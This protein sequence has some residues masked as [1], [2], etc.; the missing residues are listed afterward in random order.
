MG[1]VVFGVLQIISSYSLLQS[2][3]KI[4]QL[5]REAKKK[6]Y[7][8][9]ALT[10]VN[11]MYGVIEFYHECLAAGI[12]PILG[13][14]LDLG[15]K[16]QLL[17]LAQNERGYQNLMHISTRKMRSLAEG[18]EFF[19][20]DKED[21]LQELSIITPPQNSY[22]E[23]SVSHGKLTNAKNYLEKL[24]ALVGTSKNIYIGI[25][26]AMETALQTTL[27]QLAEQ[28]KIATVAVEPVNYLEQSD[29]FELQVLEALKDGKQLSAEQ[30]SVA[31]KAKGNAWLRPVQEIQAEYLRRGLQAPLTAMQKLCR[32]NKLQLHFSA[33]RLPHFKTPGNETAQDFL[34]KLCE[35]GLERRLKKMSVADVSAYEERLDYEL[36]V[37]H[38]M[39]FDD[40]FLIVWDVTNYAH[41]A[42]IMI[43]PGRGSAAGSLVAYALFITDVDPLRYEL[44]FERFLNEERAQMPDIDLDIPDNRRQ[45]IIRYV[46]QRYGAEHVAQ[47]ITFGTLGAKQVLRDV[48][49]VFGMPQFEMNVWSKTVPSV[50]HVTLKEAYKNSPSLR[51][52]V[53]DSEKN[54]LLFKTALALEGLPRHFSIHAAG[55]ILSDK[56][57]AD[58]VPLQV[59]NDETLLTQYTKD[60]VEEVGLLK[61]DFLGLRNLSILANAV[62]WIQSGYQQKLDVH[63]ISLD[64]EATLNL[65]QLADTTGVFQFESA[66]IKNVLRHLR[67]NSFEDIA[68]VNALYRPGPMENIDHFIRRRHG[69]EETTYPAEILKPIL[70][71]TY[72]I[73]VYQEQVMQ[74]ASAMGGFT[75][76]QADLLRRAMSKKKGAVIEQMKSRFVVGAQKKGFTVEVANQVYAYIEKFANYGFNRSHAVA[77]TKMAFQLAYIKQH[78]PAA[79][80]AS[81]LNAVIGNSSKMKD[82]LLEAKQHHIKIHAPDVNESQLLFILHKRSIYFGLQNV[83]TIR[84]DFA[85]HII[86]ERRLHGNFR[87]FQSFLQRID[88]RYLKKDPLEALI[89]AGAFDELGQNRATLVKNLPKMLSNIELSGS[90]VELFEALAPRYETFTEIGLEERLQNEEKYLGVYLSVHPVE[91]FSEVARQQNTT[92][93]SRIPE[94]KETLRFLAYIKKVKVIRTKNGQQMA[95]ATGEDQTGQIDITIFSDLYKKV[96][97]V[98]A[99]KVVML[100]SGKAEQSKRG[101]QVVARQMIPAS[102]VKLEQKAIYYIRLTNKISKDTQKQMLKLMMQNHGRTP[103]ILFEEVTAKKVMLDKRYWLQNEQR[104]VVAL[105]KLLGQE[106]VVLRNEN[107]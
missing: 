103:V 27:G 76:G 16:D 49:R 89:Y 78:Y 40:Y 79:F 6:G 25:S 34:R 105:S 90:N 69:I 77:Y 3:I 20:L 88:N 29:L 61:I 45:Q 86:A 104:V 19:K 41:Q 46:H 59:G 85:K 31:G 73:L 91:Q 10:D 95:F 93:I 56:N 74:V 57:L 35:N 22:V 11:V 52:L 106:N 72:G 51:D 80:F 67:P 102:E 15:P 5:V 100:V 47:I 64:D 26:L 13:L 65:F 94:Q 99:E 30:L 21:E 87:D 14:T 50:L 2:T 75:L 1:A 24:S 32:E 66:G 33:P 9:L 54:K 53:A 107:K 92:V 58:V 81:L 84:S 101:L 39:G 98:L 97:D 38:R 17:L 23:N 44:L 62:K 48:G 68:A 83:K 96:A 8:A 4:P 18:E 12:K 36:A 43:G 60:T 71:K 42:Q 28:L 55:I 63:N 82:Y 7:Q 37:I 70:K